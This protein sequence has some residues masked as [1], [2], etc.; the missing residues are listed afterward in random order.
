MSSQENESVTSSAQTLYLASIPDDDRG[1]DLIAIILLLWE[2]KWQVLLVSFA[3][4]TLG[5]LYAFLA[6]PVYKAI[7]SVL[8]LAGEPSAMPAKLANPPS[9]ARRP[10]ASSERVDANTA[11][12]L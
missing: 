2:K 4:G 1:I 11:L 9:R 10:A 7:A 6:T 5:G 3:F 8:S 12:A